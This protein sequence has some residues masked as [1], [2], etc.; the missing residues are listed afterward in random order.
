MTSLCSSSRSALYAGKKNISLD[1]LITFYTKAPLLSLLLRQHCLC[2][3]NQP[4]FNT[5]RTERLRE[6]KSIII[7]VSAGD[8]LDGSIFPVHALSTT[9]LSFTTLRRFLDVYCIGQVYFPLR[10]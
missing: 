1:N 7:A 2:H 3:L 9:A 10:D 8:G 4:L 6:K 5:K